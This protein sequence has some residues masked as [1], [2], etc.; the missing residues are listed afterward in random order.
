MTITSKPGICIRQFRDEDLPEVAEIFEYGM[1]LYSKNDPVSKSRWA[2][3]VRKSLKTD[4]ADVEGTY[5][6]PGGNFWVATVED[7]SGENKVAGM[8]ALEPNGNGEGEVRRVSVHPGY[9]RMGIGR[10][11]MAHLVQWATTHHFRALTLMASYA[12]KTSAV[13]F[14]T[15][16]G[17]EF[18]ETF[19]LWENPSHEVFWMTKTLP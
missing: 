6:K 10:K 9:Q 5:M 4:L 14:Y 11:L 15:S 19:M 8:I 7:N 1:M 17:F 18:G 12:E 16:F 2:D 13:K 3:Y